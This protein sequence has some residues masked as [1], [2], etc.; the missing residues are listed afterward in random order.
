MNIN[1]RSVLLVWGTLVSTRPSECVQNTTFLGLMTLPWE[2]ACRILLHMMERSLMVDDG[3]VW[4]GESAHLAKRELCLLSISQRAGSRTGDVFVIRTWSH[5]VI[6][7]NTLL[8]LCMEFWSS[9]FT[10]QS[11]GMWQLSLPL[12]TSSAVTAITL[13]LFFIIAVGNGSSGD[14]CCSVQLCWLLIRPR[15]WK[16]QMKIQ[17]WIYN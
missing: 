5:T 13:L 6:V 1:V 17:L 8:C 7:W 15:G 12:L 2:M 10:E 16:T 3:T 11:A 9:L 4:K 14:F